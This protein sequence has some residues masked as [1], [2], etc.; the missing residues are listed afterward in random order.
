MP[1]R[2]RRKRTRKSFKKRTAKRSRVTRYRQQPILEGFPK[3]K[4]VKLRYV[5]QVTLDPGLNSFSV[6]EWRA[7]SLFDT[8]SSGGGHQPMAYDQWSTIYERYCVLSSKITVQ[9][10]PAAL[11]NLNPGW[12]G[13]AMYS[14]SN[15]LQATYAGDVDRVMESK[16]VGNTTTM[17]GNFNSTNLRSR[18]V[19]YF[20]ARKFFG[21]K[22]P[23]DDPDI[24]AVVNA[25]PQNLAYFGLWYGSSGGNDPG[26]ASFKVQ[27]DFIAVMHE[28]LLLSGS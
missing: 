14:T 5:E 26:S 18:V 6:S 11:S 7:N 13:I 1:R 12:W 10:G 27:I 3:R 2:T 22:D 19:R 20:S 24:G 15:Q 8:N 25:N 17:A 21:K 28:P 16:L 23:V 9:Y 4:L